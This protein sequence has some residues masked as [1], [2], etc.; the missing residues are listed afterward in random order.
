MAKTISISKAKNHLAKYLEARKPV[1]LVGAP[2][3]GKTDIVYQVQNM[4]GADLLISHP[5]VSDPTDAKG[6]PCLVDGKARFLPFGDLDYVIN[7][8][9]DLLIWFLD[10]LG[11]APP[12]VQASYMQLLLARRI[13]GHKIPD[14]VVFVAATNR[15]EDRAGVSGILEPVKSRFHAIINIEPTVKDLAK[16]GLET[17]RIAKE[18]IVTLRLFPELLITPME[19]G[20]EPGA[21]PRTWAFATDTM[22]LFDDSPDDLFD[23]LA[24]CVGEGPA[25]QLYGVIT[26]FKDLPRISEVIKDPGSV[27]FPNEPG[28]LHALTTILARHMAKNIESADSILTFAD[29]LPGDFSV[30]LIQDTITLNS[31]LNDFVFTDTK[32]FINWNSRNLDKFIGE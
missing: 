28:K 7:Y 25:A 1:L 4:L 22:G 9:G 11:Q 30:L 18:I 20:I 12:S 17:G 31:T 23:A 32:A 16:W 6:L 24:N 13:N 14:T 15:R 2:G 29:R 21:C 3:I 10:D 5:V 19:R 26:S 8:S 27:V